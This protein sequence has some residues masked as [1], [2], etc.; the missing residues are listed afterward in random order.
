MKNILFITILLG[1]GYGQKAITKSIDDVLRGREDCED[2]WVI[3]CA[4]DDCCPVSW[5]GD[6]FEDCEDQAYG[7]DLTCY[8]NDGGDC[9]DGNPT[10]GTTGGSGGCDDCE[11]DFTAYGSEC[12]DTAWDEFGISCAELEA[13]YSWDCSGCHCP[14][15]GGWWYE[16]NDGD[17][18]Y[19]YSDSDDNDPY[20]CSD[21]DGDTCDDCST[22]TYNPY[23]D[24]ADYDADGICDLGDIDDDNDG[25]IDSEDCAP[26]YELASELDCNGDCGGS[27]VEDECG[28]CEGDGDGTDCNNDGVPDDCEEVYDEG[29][30]LGNAEG[31]TAGL[32]EGIL[33][34]GQSGD[35]NG[36]GTLDVLDIVY[37]IDVILNP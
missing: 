27:A 17:G 5:I 29:N 23:N 6:S 31:Y 10:G 4:D 15:D 3:D 16:D 19:D 9:P 26:L 14:G 8:D 7:C 11:F 22:G 13:D 21:N 30:D 37:F 35:A 1:V 20:A 32:E 24:G 28:V 36:D 2:G 34:G 18:V 25:V 33:L 12:C